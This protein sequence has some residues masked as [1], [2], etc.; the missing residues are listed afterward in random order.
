MTRS[1][2]ANPLECCQELF[3]RIFHFEKHFQYFCK[4]S[5]SIPNEGKLGWLSL[6]GLVQNFAENHD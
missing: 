1:R 2:A 4:S 6:S 3:A 5:S